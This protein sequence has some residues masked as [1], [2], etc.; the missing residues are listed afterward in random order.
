[1]KM[2]IDMRFKT[3]KEGNFLLSGGLKFNPEKDHLKD[4][5]TKLLIPDNNGDYFRQWRP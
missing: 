2:D 4:L 5:D 3:D 1:M